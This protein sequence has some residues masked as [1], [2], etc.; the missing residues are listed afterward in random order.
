MA[1]LWGQCKSGNL[2]SAAVM[3]MGIPEKSVK[4]LS[5]NFPLGTVTINTW[6]LQTTCGLPAK[7]VY[8]LHSLIST[9]RRRIK[10]WVDQLL[11][12][13]NEIQ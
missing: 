8:L 6:L 7:N 10:Y 2:I 5:D 9:T 12:A 11:V 1:T 13:D 3:L 4:A